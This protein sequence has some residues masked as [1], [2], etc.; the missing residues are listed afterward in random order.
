MVLYLKNIECTTGF[1]RRF[2]IVPFTVT[3]PEGK[4]DK[5]LHQKIIEAGLD[6]IFNWL[7]EGAKRVIQK[8]D[9]FISNECKKTITEFIKD[10]D[11]V[12]QFL[13]EYNLTKSSFNRIYIKDLYNKYKNWAQESG[14]KALGKKQ[15]SKRLEMLG[16]KKGKDKS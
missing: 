13:E 14:I 9:I 4:R 15:F 16:F 2:I 11:S 5:R 12:L 8:E 1:F 6:G 3:I 7:L 10:V